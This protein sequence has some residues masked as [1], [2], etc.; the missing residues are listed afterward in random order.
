MG[1][2]LRLGNPRGA[3]SS[4]CAYAPCCA[5]PCACPRRSPECSGFPG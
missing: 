4:A 1:E 2:A 3:A 5:A